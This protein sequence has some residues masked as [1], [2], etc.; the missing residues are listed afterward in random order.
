[1][2]SLSQQSRLNNIL[3]STT[4]KPVDKELRYPRDIIAD[5]TDYFKIEVLKYPKRKT[6]GGNFA[7]VMKG[8]TIS[9]MT[10]NETHDAASGAL[11]DKTIILPIPRNIQDQN[12]A[13]W[14][15]DQ[16]NDYSA[17]LAQGAMSIMES[18]TMGI[19]ALTKAATSGTVVDNATAIINDT[20]TSARASSVID[21]IKARAAA[22][23]SNIAGGN[24]SAEGLRTRATG[25][26]VNQNTELLFN[27]V[28][29]RAFD[30]SWD[31]VPRSGDEAL[32]VKRIIRLLK[33]RLAP[34]NDRS[35]PSGFLN[36]PDI[37]RISYM[38]GGSAHPFLN[39]FKACA[40]SNM[41]VNYTASGTYATYD[42]GSPVH[43]SM[44]LKFQ[45]LN[46]VYAEDYGDDG[47][48]G[49]GY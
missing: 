10:A 23:V 40:L 18:P 21:I 7:D 42:D 13:G 16:L 39:S 19:N 28:K 30:F 37:F 49:V 14:R 9:N 2:A 43:L 1:V 25:S 38:K 5:T 32:V 26:I 17:I 15:E 3:P 48:L 46:P 31:I 36:S 22:A 24:V 6:E 44:S 12:G 34:K 20:V 33:T 35:N 41:T 27:S 47:L 11:A 8:S 29:M 4:K 45:E